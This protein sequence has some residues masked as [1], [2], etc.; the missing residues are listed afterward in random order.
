MLDSPIQYNP[1]PVGTISFHYRLNVFFILLQNRCKKLNYIM[2]IPNAIKEPMPKIPEGTLA[3]TPRTEEG[4]ASPSQY[5]G[6]G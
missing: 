4:G 5:E 2:Y 1:A 6:P 3:P